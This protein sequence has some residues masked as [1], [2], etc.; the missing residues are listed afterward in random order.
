VRTNGLKLD[1]H[2]YPS[3]INSAL[4]FIDGFADGVQQMELDQ[5]AKWWTV[6]RA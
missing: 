4:Y 2:F 3:F 6:N 5:T 1:C